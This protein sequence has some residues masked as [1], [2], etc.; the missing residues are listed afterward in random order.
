M[1]SSKLPF[2]FQTRYYDLLDLA[3]TDPTT[4]KL[5]G[6]RNYR[7]LED[8]LGNLPTAGAVGAIIQ[9][10]GATGFTTLAVGAGA[11]LCSTSVTV[12]SDGANYFL[13]TVGFGTIQVPNPEDGSVLQMSGSL[14]SQPTLGSGWVTGSSGAGPD[15]IDTALLLQPITFA[16]GFAA[17]E[18]SYPL[19]WVTSTFN[20]TPG[21]QGFNLEASNGNPFGTSSMD[22]SG[23]I[24]TTVIRLP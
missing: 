18:L 16:T 14:K 21:V 2:E 11:V 8:Y 17:L 22:F 15:V 1:A 10:V 12:P 4:A 19:S 13:E 9:K 3:Q 20:P 6:E 7:A 23:V 5:L 24:T